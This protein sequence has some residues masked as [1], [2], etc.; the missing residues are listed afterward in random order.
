MPSRKNDRFSSYSSSSFSSS[1]S[2]SQL[3]TPRAFQNGSSGA[4]SKSPLWDVE[5]TKGSF[6]YSMPKSNEELKGEI[7]ELET[8]I[9]QLEG[10]LLSLYRTSFRDHFPAFLSPDDSSLPQSKPYTTKFH[11]DQVSS[12][13]DTS[14]L[15]SSKQLSET[16]IIKISDSGHPSLADL[17]GLNTLSPNKLSEEIVRLICV[18]HFNLSGKGQ[19]KVVKNS[20]NEEYGEELGVVIHK[21]CLDEDNLK[22]VESLLQNFRSLIQKLEKVDPARMTREEKLAFWI[23]IHNALV[24]HAHIIY[25]IGEHTTSTMIL[26]APFNIGGEWVNAYDVQSSILGIRACHSSSRLR[27]LFSPARSSKTSSSGHIYTLEYA[28]PLLHFALSTGASTDPMVRV[29]TAEGIFQ[30]LRQARDG[31]VQKSFGF[32]KDTR[33]LLPKIIHNYA[34]DTSLDMAELFNTITE[35][36][37]D[38]QII[39]MRSVVKKKQDRCIYWI[40]HDSSFRYIIHWEIVRESVGI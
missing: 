26:K 34:K 33:V 3:N 30:E 19:S 27:T 24:M 8:E 7:A 12:V 18:I 11:N 17:L 29:Y 31:F 28:E 9:L 32:E 38:T 1:S 36:L 35:C 21:L 23:N 37:T 4:I 20:K 40:K 2:S 5:K 6:G 16:D 14:L 25:G 15:S 39:K 22:S 13:S 10:Y